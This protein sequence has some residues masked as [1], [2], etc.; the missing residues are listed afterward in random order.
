MQ[1]SRQISDRAE[2]SKVNSESDNFTDFDQRLKSSLKIK[3]INDNTSHNNG[4]IGSNINEKE[5]FENEIIDANNKDI[6]TILDNNETKK[7]EI[8][9]QRN[10]D[11][12]ES[13]NV[14]NE[15][16]KPPASAGR[17]ARR[18]DR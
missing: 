7:S 8:K 17:I 14:I 6:I 5:E 1:K 13:I 9:S 16:W 10:I 2:I 4:L 11:I 12:N 18:T 15:T 3:R